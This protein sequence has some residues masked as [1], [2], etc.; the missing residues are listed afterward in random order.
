MQI[1]ILKEKI[2]EVILPLVIIEGQIKKLT[3]T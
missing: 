3:T 1:A 2:D